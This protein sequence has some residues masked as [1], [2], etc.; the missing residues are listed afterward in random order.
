MRLWK[1]GPLLG[2]MAIGVSGCTPLPKI[3]DLSDR[4]AEITT[5]GEPLAYQAE[6]PPLDAGASITHLTLLNASHLVLRHDPSIQAALAR[7]RQ[8]QAEAKQTRLLPN[9]I[10][11]VAVRLPEGGGRATVEAGVTAELLSLITQPGRISAADHRLRASVAEALATVLDRLHTVRDQYTTVQ[12]LAAQ[13][14][15]AES[16]TKTLRELVTLAEARAQVGE[17]ARMDVL[18]ARSDL[19]AADTELRQ[20]RSDERQARITLARLIGRPSDRATWRIDPWT[21]PPALSGDEADFVRLALEHRPDLQATVW[22]LHAL[23]EQTRIS[24][25][26]S[27]LS[28]DAGVEAEREDGWTIGPAASVPIPLFDLG[29]A[30]KESAEAQLVE[31]RHLLIERQR[32]AVE[33]VRLAIESLRSHQNGLERSQRELIPLQT[34]RLEQARRAYQLGLTDVMT[35][36]QAEQD[37]QSA[38]AQVVTLEERVAKAVNA[39]EH[40]VGGA[41]VAQRHL[42]T[43]TV[44]TTPST[45]PA[46]GASQP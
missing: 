18:A 22:E 23:G 31:Q 33:E 19:V 43:T 40:A 32:Q 39:L 6:T 38:R 3:D 29:H 4:A 37:L 27:F 12:S 20:L 24:R 26:S 14:E 2:A 21:A 44:P 28:G 5:V 36:R 15:I 16:R 17:A 25:M 1:A 45:H 8:A 30:A 34:E 35:V 11:R 46:T 7:V 42:Q 41:G 13:V 9:P 10:L